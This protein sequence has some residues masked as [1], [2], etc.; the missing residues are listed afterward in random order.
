[1]KKAI[2]FVKGAFVGALAGATAGVLFAP[3]SG[4]ETREDIKKKAVEVKDKFETVYADATDALAKKVEN[5]KSLGEVVDETKYRELVAEVLSDF[6]ESK[7]LDAKVARKL[8][9]QMRKDWKN[10]KKTLK[11]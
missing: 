8:G 9:A 1:M 3:K 7:K 5:L 10:V 6:K 4:K 11:A 2:S